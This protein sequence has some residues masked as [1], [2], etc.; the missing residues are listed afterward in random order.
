[1]TEFFVEMIVISFTL[2]GV[3]GS[4][5]A[6]NLSTKKKNIAEV[7]AEEKMQNILRP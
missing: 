4:I 6:L 2:G 3:I 7:A 5:V 1:M